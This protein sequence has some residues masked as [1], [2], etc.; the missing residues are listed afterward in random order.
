MKI[1][2][3]FINREDTSSKNFAGIQ[4]KKSLFSSLSPL[5]LTFFIL[6]SLFFVTCDNIFVPPKPELIP[7]GNGILLLSINQ[8]NETRTIKPTVGL[9]NFVR[10]DLEFTAKTA[11]NTSFTEPWTDI[12]GTIELPG[13]TWELIVTAY[14]EGESGELLEAAKSELKTI[15]VPSGGTLPVDILLLPIEE[16]EGTFSWD[17]NFNGI[18]KSAVMDILRVERIDTTINLSLEK[19]IVF[20]E[21]GN[22][23]DE[24]LSSKTI[25]DAGEYRVV[26]KLSNGEED[27]AITM[28]LHIYQNIESFFEETFTDKHFPVTLL[29]YIL[30]T[31]DGNSWKLSEAGILAEHFSY[32]SINGVSDDNFGNVVRWFNTICAD[33]IVPGD[34]EELKA[35]VDAALIGLASEDAGFL[36]AGKYAYLYEIEA[37]ISALIKNDTYLDFNW[38]AN[39]TIIVTKLGIYEIIFNVQLLSPTPGLRFELS[40]ANELAYSVH[41]GNATDAVVV[42]PAVWEGLPVR[43][44]GDMRIRMSYPSPYPDYAFSHYYEMTS[45]IIPNSVTSISDIAFGGC[46]SLTN[47]TIPNSVTIIGD[48]AFADCTS[49]TN[50]TIPNSVTSIGNWAFSGCNSLTNITIPNSVTSIGDFAFYGCTSLTSVTIPASVT[51]ISDTALLHCYN[52]TTVFYEGTSLEWDGITL[53]W[54]NIF[55]GHLLYYSETD[56]GTIYTHWRWVEGQPLVWGWGTIE[57]EGTPGLFFTL[58]DGDTAYSV[59]R[60][61]AIATEMVIPNVY[62]GLPVTAIDSVGFLVYTNMMSVTIPDSVTL[63]GDGAFQGCSSLTSVSIG[64]SV[65]NIGGSAF[66]GCAGLTSIEIPDSV[67]SIGWSAFEDCTGLTSVTI[68]N[69][70]TSIGLWAFRGCNS[71]SAI[72]YGGLNESA[73]SAIDIGQGNQ[74]L[75][76][77]STT[78]YYYSESDPG[79][80]NTHW[81]WVSGE[82]LLWMNITS[83]MGIEMVWVPAGSFRM[84]MNGDGSFGNEEPVHTVTLNDGFYMGKYQVTQ[85]QWEAVMGSNPSYFPNNPASGETQGRRPVEMVSWYDAIVFCNLLSMAESLTP[86]YSIDGETNPDIWITTHGAVP[87]GWNPA[88]RWNFVVI[89]EGSTGYRLPTEAQWE[90]AAKGGNGLG[91]YFIYSGSDDPNEVAWYGFMAGGSNNHPGTREVGKKAANS[92]GIHDMSGNVLEWCWDCLSEYTDTAK[93]DPVGATTGSFRLTRGGGWLLNSEGSVRSTFRAD[94]LPNVRSD[95]LGFRLLRP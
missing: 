56:P 10:F 59:S 22:I 25:L 3:Y 28:I 95:D 75:T 79:T 74:P 6:C 32:L 89:V 94:L 77:T 41:R 20:I 18:I 60:G 53:N 67:T 42:I 57:Y 58:I 71:L 40:T 93:T 13:G 69:S 15:T 33:R 37:L 46:T 23:Q 91:P 45:I 49:L 9:D 51:S 84:G 48:Y 54:N 70:V 1:D 43:E 44:I 7:S 62:N 50:I 38:E 34:T 78:I 85:E 72:F 55:A 83:P 36:D 61:L 19:T 24:Y 52:L 26:F 73:W 39:N 81:R 66:S 64:N 5:W 17:I 90:Y 80:A 63:I 87:T 47:I 31:W 16:G 8:N 76:F 82:P 86:A 14:L 4:R 35:L 11:G 65:T 88:S 29:N 12:S 27:A 30:D 92:L 21:S 2:K 68:G